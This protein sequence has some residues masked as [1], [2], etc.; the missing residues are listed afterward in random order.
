MKKI[1]FDY[2]ASRYGWQKDIT[3]ELTE[4]QEKA[5]KDAILPAHEYFKDQGVDMLYYF[6]EVF[7]DEELYKLV[8]DSICNHYVRMIA[9]ENLYSM[10][11]DMFDSEEMEWIEDLNQER[12]I[13]F[14][15][16]SME[17]S[18]ELCVEDMRIT[19]II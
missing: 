16:D 18:P 1:T 3:I 9:T 6:S 15:V 13:D 10:G 11:L 2:K 5:F 17:E 19:A 7:K 8:S 4:E 12:R 14:A